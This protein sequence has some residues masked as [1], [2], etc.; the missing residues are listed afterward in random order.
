MVFEPGDGD[1]PSR[2]EREQ[3]DAFVVGDRGSL[4]KGR[5]DSEGSG[6]W[7]EVVR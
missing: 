7:S 4:F 6:L 2:G 5:S 3:L 1:T